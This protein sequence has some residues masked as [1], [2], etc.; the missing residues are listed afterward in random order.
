MPI[1]NN[2]PQIFDVATQTEDG[3]M[4]YQDKIKLDSLD[5][6]LDGK[7][8][9]TDK[10]PSSQLDTSSDAAKIQ[11]E[12]LSDA[13]KRMMTGE[14][15]VDSTV[16]NNGVTTE[17][18]ATNAVTIDK[19]DK[20]VILGN[21]VSPRPL[22]FS[23]D[24]KKVTITVPQGSLLLLDGTTKRNLVTGVD[25]ED[26]TINLN[27]PTNFDGLNYIISAPDGTLSIINNRNV[28]TIPN[29]N[30]IIALVTLT[31]NF[32]TT[33][34][35]N[36]NYTING[37]AQ[38]IGTESAALLGNGKIV[39]DKLTGIIDFTQATEL[40]LMIG[41]VYKTTIYTQA[42]IRLA[43]YATDTIYS[44]YWDNPT[45]SLKTVQ[46]SAIN[47]DTD[48]N[49]IAIIKDGRIIPF[50]NT[51]IF[52]SKPYIEA[53]YYTETF[54]NID[55]IGISSNTPINIVT[56][57]ECKL[58]FFDETYVY[59]NQTDLLVKNQDC[60]YEDREGMHYILFDVDAQT[61]S[62]RHNKQ[63]GD[64]RLYIVL[65][66][67]WITEGKFPE[68]TG[69]FTYTV[70]GKTV[71][72]DDLSNINQELDTLKTVVGTDNNISA[73]KILAPNELYMINGEDAHIYSSSMLTFEAEGIRPAISY[74]KKGDEMAPVTRFFDGD[75][76]LNSTDLGDTAE[77]L[78]VEKYNKGRYL[79]KEVKINK[80]DSTSKNGQTVKILCL[81]D[82]LI[83]DKSA[84][85]LKNKLTALGVTPTMLGTMVNNQVYGEGRDGWFYSTFVGASGRGYNEGKI[86]PQTSKGASS[87]LLNPFI[88][89]ANADDK[90]N[91]PNDC[92]RATGAYVE[93]N[94]YND[95][96]KG[97]AFYIFDFGKYLEL[98]G[99]E[100]PDVVLIAIKPEMVSVFTEDI[101]S[102]N[103]TYLKQLVAGIRKALPTT[104][105]GL[106]PQYASSLASPE[107]WTNTSTMVDEV[108]RYVA[109][110]GDNRLKVIP[111]WLHM[112]REFGT[113]SFANNSSIRTV[114]SNDQLFED[115]ILDPLEYN[116]SEN[117]KI[118]LANSLTAFIMNI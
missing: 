64:D 101:T 4:S 117:A 31:T 83:N 21:I 74:K 105:I 42:S 108:T 9:K 38:G 86:T 76:V 11:P 112:C 56:D 93:K 40:Y 80:V 23:F 5:Q 110:S 7:V 36:G 35:M 39:F 41:G 77:L 55:T 68:V 43:D 14:S 71:Y 16:P 107:T 52:Y 37:L 67:M 49:K 89:T 50:V 65:G 25:T 91:Y 102:V 96:D 13:V 79:K 85:Y 3:L 88:R 69:N 95:T 111:A 27:Y 115:T 63:A 34:V 84:Y 19:I 87:I 30:T 47:P 73:N 33:I 12:N 116:L 57:G 1:E 59:L 54:E 113:A 29:T 109:S 82:D 51:G 97:G 75:I 90:A 28:T 48:I 66:S 10:I 26:V 94:Y 118:E 100:T 78:A 24:T 103:M 62:C 18:L 22:N 8:S 104:I 72:Q 32:E 98:Q 70:N 46:V 61:I 81:G 92:Y 60:Y 53:P 17:K 58:E 20:R 44:L 15:A 6:T 45:S 99:I 114:S 106:V 2:L